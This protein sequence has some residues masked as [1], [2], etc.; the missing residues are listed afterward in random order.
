M[1]HHVTN[2]FKKV[3]LG[4]VALFALAF[5]PSCWFDTN[6]CYTEAYIVCD[7]DARIRRS[8]EP[9]SVFDGTHHG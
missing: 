5:L 3:A 8:H 9:S 6:N 7:N 4:L 1:T 2:N